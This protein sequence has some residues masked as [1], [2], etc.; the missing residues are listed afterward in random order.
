VLPH[1]LGIAEIKLNFA[2]FGRIIVIHALFCSPGTFEGKEPLSLP[3]G[4]SA[5][6]AQIS[7]LIASKTHATPE[8]LLG[9]QPAKDTCRVDQL[10]RPEFWNGGEVAGAGLVHDQH[11]NSPHF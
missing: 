4:A 8:S 10:R 5:E 9:L 6:Q 11:R 3:I 2:D 7:D 1:D